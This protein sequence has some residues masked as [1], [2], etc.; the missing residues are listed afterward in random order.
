VRD[1]IFRDPLP[2]NPLGGTGLQVH[3][4]CAGCAP[5]AGMSTPYAAVTAERQA[6]ETIR[7][8]LDS[9]IHFIDT[10]ASYGNGESERRIGMVLRERGG[11]PPHA[12]L[13]TKAGRDAHNLY[14]GAS[15][16]AGVERSLNLLGLERLQLVYL[17]DPE[18]ITFEQALA[19]NGPVAALQRCKAEGLIVHIG[20][21]G[22]PVDLMMRYVETGLFEVA[23]SHNRFTLLNA[24]ASPL[25]D[26]CR[27][28]GVAA[29]NAAPY[30]GGIL[31]LGPRAFPRY[32]YHQASPA[33]LERAKRL[34]EICASYDVPLAAAAL[35]FSLR[36]PRITSTIVGIGAPEQLSETLALAQLTMPDDLWR[37]LE[38]V[39]RSLDDPRDRDHVDDEDWS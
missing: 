26:L 13:A 20:V 9:P 25:W 1:T 14:T 4:L 31:V 30:G 36:E 17:H 15:V 8:I 32:A 35:Q 38:S 22:G 19:P 16:R 24:A 37:D 11:L 39:Q 12:V 3:S 23:I 28:K 5:L 2:L 18:H 29:I 27:R 7:V 10:A 33:L 21:A 6:L 34:E